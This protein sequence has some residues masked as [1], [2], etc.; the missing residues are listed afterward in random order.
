MSAFA[1][2]APDTRR[3]VR[4]DYF[5]YLIPTLIGQIAHSF[6]CMA[7]VFFVGAAVGS[8]GLA[9][10]NVALPVFTLFSAFSLMVGVGTATTVSILNGQGQPRQSDRVFSQSM[11][12]LA[13]TGLVLSVLTSVWIVPLAR[14]FG[15]TDRILTGVVEYMRPINL[16]AFVYVFSG[17]LGVIIRADGNP[18]L[19][20]FAGTTGNLCNILLDYLFTMRMGM[21]MFGAGL[22]TILGHCVAVLLY[23]LHFALRRNQVRFVSR[24]LDPAAALRVLKNG[25]GSSILELSAGLIVL[26][27]NI[28]LLRVSGE[29]AVAIFSV[30]S[31]IAYVGKGVFNGMA[32]AA[33][34]ILSTSY[35][36]GRFDRVRAANRCAMA[37]AA[38]FSCGIYL[39]LVLFAGS[40][41]P[42]F[43]EPSLVPMGVRALRLY[44]LAF[45]FTGLNTVM[46]YAFQ[47][48]EKVRYTS[49]IAVLRGVVLITAFL[50]LFSLLWGETGV[51]LALFA[52]EA[53]TY[54]VFA[55]VRTRVD[56]S[57]AQPTALRPALR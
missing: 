28:A 19:V 7:D 18:R 51:W 2:V 37:T 32:Q 36:A 43:V 40:I 24:F 41:M 42:V 57:L 52:A 14:V 47:S 49:V 48:L 10:L 33:Q 15:A 44:F 56:H 21:G 23:L 38:L 6:Y 22:A 35:G 20:M 3:E 8:D 50:S 30:L 16:L 27:F 1:S 31:N 11:A 25:I 55:P 54:L 34:P 45:P 12:L 13:L 9:A 29:S 17:A 5:R 39:I 53:V 4:Q 26:L 46:M